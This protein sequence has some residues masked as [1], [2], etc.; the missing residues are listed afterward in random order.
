MGQFLRHEPCPACGSKDGLA[1][2]VAGDAHCFSCNA[3][4]RSADDAQP[5]QQGG[6]K[7]TEFL[8]G[9]AVAIP[10]RKLTQET[11]EKWG[12]WV[13]TDQKGSKVHI[14]NYR[15]DVGVRVAQKIRGANKAF[16][17]VGDGKKLPLYGQ[18]LW[19]SGG[20]FCTVTE[21]EIDALSM[22]QAM[23]NK[24]TVVSLPHG[25]QSAAKALGD[26]LEWLSQFEHIVLCFDM[27][28]PGRAAVEE[29]CKVLPQGRVKVMNLPRKD[30][31]DVLV[32]LGPEALVDAFWKA[33]DWRP[34]G[35][36]AGTEI[37]VEKLTT[38]VAKGYDLPYPIA[39]SMLMGIRKREITLLTA[40]TGIGKSTLAREW[41]YLLSQGHGCK[42]GNVFLEESNE[43]TAQAYI[44]VH[45]NVALK[46]LRYNPSIL[47]D[48]V[49]ASSLKDVVHGKMWFYDHF[50]SLGSDQLML[51]LRYLATVIKVDF[52]VLDHISIVVSGVESSQGERKDIDVLMTKLRS[53]VE[54][55]GV[56]VIAIVHLNQPE[57]KPHEEGGRITLRNLR[58]SGGLKQMS[59]T[60]FALERDQQ[61]AN[62]TMAQIRILKC[63]ETGDVGVADWLKYDKQ[64]GRLLVAPAP[65]EE[66]VDFSA[67]DDE[68]E[69]AF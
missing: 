68:R 33:R 23:N 15:N 48:A 62:P 58:G 22:S 27:D 29:A 16:S 1:R 54:E 12:Y 13:G 8:K 69:I 49:W 59:D 45:N 67:T 37:T 44:A 2:Y 43:K 32:K 21:G 41:A 35:I 50:G 56:G 38:A 18:W 9:E 20:K 31:S 47:P 51:K 61:G 65:A 64:T 53:L 30:A 28:K 19:P 39:N 26:Q 42:I 52:I 36:I 25:A 7:T 66:V 10:E 3:N 46:D 6:S 17:V 34:D 4:F 57:G 5:I 40:G 63:R 11:C 14:A 55:T 60:V 24:W